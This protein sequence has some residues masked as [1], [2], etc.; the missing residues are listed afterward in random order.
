MTR[1]SLPTVCQCCGRQLKAWT[2]SEDVNHLCVR[3]NAEALNENAHSD[4]HHTD[5]PDEN[6]HVCTATDPHAGLRDQTV[7]GAQ[8]KVLTDAD[9]RLGV[10]APAV[11]EGAERVKL[12]GF[13]L[14]RVAAKYAV[15]TEASVIKRDAHVFQGHASWV[16]VMIDGAT[17]RRWFWTE[18][19]APVAVRRSRPSRRRA[20]PEAEAAA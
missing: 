5:A 3:C 10:N 20:T 13:R 15:G 1:I 17:Q 7:N 19:V 4:G 9:G 16:L 2:V 18:D 12:T 14:G 8:G 11:P 6:C